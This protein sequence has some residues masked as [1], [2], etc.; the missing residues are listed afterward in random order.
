MSVEFI[1]VAISFAVIALLLL[2]VLVIRRKRR[3]SSA[4]HLSSILQPYIRD[5]ISHFIIPDGI[6]G[7]IE[8]EHLVQMDQGL[9]LIETYPISGNLFGAENIDL[10]TQI[11]DGRSYKFSNPLRHIRASRQA[12]KSILPNIPIFCRVVFTSDSL[13]PKGKPEGVSVLKNLAEDLSKIKDAP[14]IV[15]RTQAGWDRLLRIARKDGQAVQRVGGVD[16]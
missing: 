3:Y 11:I 1:S 8:I 12:I 6:G 10:W 14:A 2:I 16:G 13:F 9:L 4:R 5:E 15:T 7:L